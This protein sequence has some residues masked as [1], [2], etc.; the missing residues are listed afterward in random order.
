MLSS[1][2]NRNK[3]LEERKLNHSELVSFSSNLSRR[4]A[5]EPIQYI[6]GQWDFYNLQG[7]REMLSLFYFYAVT[8]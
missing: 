1:N 5:L 2:G 4:I 7:I 6:L 8:S 3:K